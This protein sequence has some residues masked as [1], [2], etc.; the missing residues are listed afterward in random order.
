MIDEQVKRAMSYDGWFTKRYQENLGL[1]FSTMK[2][3]VS[4][5]LQRP[6]NVIVETGTTRL[7]D[8][9]GGGM[10]TLV[11]GEVADTF[12]SK[13]YTVDIDGYNMDVSR[14]I[15]TQYKNSIEYVV[16]D[17]VE[18]FQ[19]YS[20]DPIGLLY[21]D[22]YDYP[23][24]ELLDIYGG[25]TDINVAKL[26]LGKMSEEEIVEKH[27]HIIRASQNHCLNELR[28]ALPHTTADTVI[29]IDDCDLPGG[30]KGRTAKN[31]LANQGY[32]CV[33]DNY[34]SLWIK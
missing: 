1:R 26:I 34:Q 10:S 24:G 17:S 2:A 15:T 18:F 31:F 30:G 8:D 23:Y 33:L 11:L 32:T 7:E 9:W 19:K 6:R 16:S 27:G 3:A 28:A 14:K 29:L 5:Y 13:L 20:G 25:K 21:L 22:S 4:L 12:K